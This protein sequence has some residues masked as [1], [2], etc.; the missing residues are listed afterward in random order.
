MRLP[1][2]GSALVAP[3]AA[4][5]GGSRPPRRPDRRGLTDD[6]A[7]ADFASFTSFLLGHLLLEVASL[8]GRCRPTRRPRRRGGPRRK[9]IDHATVERLGEALAEDHA[10]VEFEVGLE[11]LLNH[12]AL[13]RSEETLD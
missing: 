6:A 11:D 2:D 9:P 12:I 1:S 7:V 5:L 8:G 3:A 10:A 4:Q 13:E